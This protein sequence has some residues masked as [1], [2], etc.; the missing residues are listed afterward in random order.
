MGKRSARI[1]TSKR[2]LWTSYATAGVLT[3]ILVTATLISDHDLTA[4]ATITGLSWG[5]VTAVTAFYLWKAKA[6][7]KIKITKQMVEELADK[8]G[9]EAVSGL[10]STIFT[11]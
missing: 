5:E 4:L 11:D 9:L 7:N 3:I 10:L 6:E 8:Y 1:S 2:L